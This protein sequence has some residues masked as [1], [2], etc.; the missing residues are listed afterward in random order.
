MFDTLLIITLFL[1]ASLLVGLLTLRL[2]IN[3]KHLSVFPFVTNINGFFEIP[4][5]PA[6]LI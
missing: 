2:S 6:Y 5:P 1:I 3:I 4:P